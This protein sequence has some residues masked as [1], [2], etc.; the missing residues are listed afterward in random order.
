MSKKDGYFIVIETL[1]DR[2]KIELY[3]L[4]IKIN[5]LDKFLNS[6]T[7]KFIEKDKQILLKKLHN[8]MVEYKSILEKR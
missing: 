4:D 7:F 3:E 6:D 1:L 2:F 8:V 5:K